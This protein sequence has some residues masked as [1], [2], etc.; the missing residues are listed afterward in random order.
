MLLMYKMI[1]LSGAI[2]FLRFA[3]L[4]KWPQ[5][6]SNLSQTAPP[7]GCNQPPPCWLHPLG[8]Q[9]WFQN[10]RKWCP[11]GSIWLPIYP[12]WPILGFKATLWGSGGHLFRAP[13]PPKQKAGPPPF[14]QEQ[15]AGPPP[16]G[17]CFDYI[18][19]GIISSARGLKKKR[20][21]EPNLST[22]FCV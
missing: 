8:C 3:S 7:N 13:R 21:K 14:G 18:R 9:K 22:S 5:M 15:K 19:R 20:R 2:A 12:R 4:P 10:D 17:Q 11:N 16:F 6:A 1:A